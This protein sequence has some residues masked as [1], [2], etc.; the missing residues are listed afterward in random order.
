MRIKKYEKELVFAGC[1]MLGLIYVGM[2]CNTAGLYFSDMA[3]DLRVSM[4]EV[5]LTMS[6]LNGG[7]LLGML[8]AGKMVGKIDLRILMSVCTAA[9]GAGL[10]GCAVFSD[11][12]PYYLVW[13]MIGFSAPFL[14]SVSVPMLLGRFFSDRI[15]AKL[16]IIYGIAGVGGAAFNTVVGAWIGRFGWRKS[17][18]IEGVLALLCLLPFTVSVLRLETGA[19][20]EKKRVQKT[21]RGRRGQKNRKGQENGCEPEKSECADEKNRTVRQKAFWLFM[22]VNIVLTVVSSLV[23]Q[24]SPHI[25]NLGFD[26][27]VS[28]AVMSGIMI[29]CAVGNVLIGRLLD[30]FRTEVVTALFLL[31]GVAG[32]LSMT[33]KTD[34][35]IMVAAGVLVGFGQAVFQ[36]GIPFCVQ[37]IFGAR[38]YGAVYS[39][40]CMP[41][42]IAGIFSAALG[43]I[44]FDMTGSYV[45]MILLL[46]VMDAAAVPCI[47]AGMRAGRTAKDRQQ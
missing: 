19:G 36:T 11:I 25:R 2:I 22:S 32:M 4:A 16:G 12:W 5:T 14:M 15:G 27:G 39:V 29:G 31:C 41:G 35:R 42:S 17:F 18:L 8:A 46:A 9:C 23:Q 33:W 20:Q 37:K 40:L 43:G 44:I 3:S 28:A 45:P 13:G 47:A 10:A 30:R 6:F 7:G 26:I 1:C 38:E 24:I 21:K 34:N